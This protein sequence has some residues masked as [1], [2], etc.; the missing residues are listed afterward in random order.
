MDSSDESGSEDL[1][2][3]YELVKAEENMEKVKLIKRELEDFLEGHRQQV[4]DRL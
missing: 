2:D 4:E 1:L 3:P